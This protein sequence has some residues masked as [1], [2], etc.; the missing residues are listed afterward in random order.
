MEPW[1][2]AARRHQEMRVVRKELLQLNVHHVWDC[3]RRRTH[4]DVTEEFKTGVLSCRVKLVR[5]VLNFIE[6]VRIGS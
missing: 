1:Y 2:R 4:M 6:R 3:G 5:A